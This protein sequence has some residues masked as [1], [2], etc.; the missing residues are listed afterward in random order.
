MR[1]SLFQALPRRLKEDIL[2]QYRTTSTTLVVL[3][4]VLVLVVVLLLG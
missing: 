4:L 1:E 2:V 3:V